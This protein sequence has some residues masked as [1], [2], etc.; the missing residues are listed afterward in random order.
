[1]LPIVDE[2]GVL[3]VVLDDVVNGGEGQSTH[4]VLPV[5]GRV[6]VEMLA[7]ER[8]RTVGCV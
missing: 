6:N 8:G 4:G 7:A 5:W 1:M 2:E 3:L